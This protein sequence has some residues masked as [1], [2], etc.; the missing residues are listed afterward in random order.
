[1]A[2]E[3]GLAEQIR[4]G[5]DDQPVQ[6]AKAGAPVLRVIQGKN[7]LEQM[8]HG[9]KVREHIRE[10]GALIALILVTMSAVVFYRGGSDVKAFSYLG[11]GAI[12][13]LLGSRAP[14]TLHPIWSGWMK[15][16]EKLSV[17]STFAI[18]M[19]AWCLLVIPM[20]MLLRVFRINVMNMSFRAPVETYWDTRAEK[21][22]DFKLLERQF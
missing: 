19:I 4:T 2:G 14:S 8:F 18:L 22:H 3:R 15:F 1:M 20:A 11:A 9:R 6:K 10:F 17:V 7:P 21:L 5:L 16:A 12:M 13:L